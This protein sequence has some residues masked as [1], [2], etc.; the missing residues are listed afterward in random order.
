M[1]FITQPP[2]QIPD[3]AIATY[4]WFAFWPITIKKETRWLERVTVEYIY[5]SGY[6]TALPGWFPKRFL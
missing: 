6:L 1:K 5:F 2:P 4:S 3:G